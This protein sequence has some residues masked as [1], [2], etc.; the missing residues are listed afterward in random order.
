M[1]ND[2]GDGSLLDSDG[3]TRDINGPATG[4]NAERELLAAPV[5]RFDRHPVN[6]QIENVAVNGG[7]TGDQLTWPVG[8]I[9]G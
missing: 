9:T 2:H 5:N 8:G 6:R 3:C 7:T 4:V 1:N